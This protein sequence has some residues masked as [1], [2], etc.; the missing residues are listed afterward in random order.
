MTRRIALTL[1]LVALFALSASSGRAAPDDAPAG[2]TL[3][4]GDP[5][6]A[7]Q[8]D[9]WL[10]GEPVKELE[11][12]KIYVIECWAT[13][14]GPCI[15]SMPHVTKMQAKF[16]DKGVDPEVNSYGGRNFVRIDAYALPMVRR[17]SAGFNLQY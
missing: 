16:K 10:K 9:K 2:V 8:L 4:V 17:L 5:A 1:S 12:G 15:A 11:K 13:W 14:C 6:P 7:L 3:K